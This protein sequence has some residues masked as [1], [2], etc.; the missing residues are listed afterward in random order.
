MMVSRFIS[1]AAACRD[2]T[3]L[4]IIQKLFTVNTRRYESYFIIR[5]TIYVTQCK[6]ASNYINTHA[7]PFNG[8]FSRTIRVILLKQ[9]TVSGSGISWEICKSAPRARQITTPAIHHSVFYRPCPSNYMKNSVI[10][11]CSFK[12]K[13]FPHLLRYCTF[14]NNALRNHNNVYHQ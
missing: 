11:H 10:F 5:V 4:H 7:Q 9:E 14:G 8:L 2:C 12:I 1:S 6:T 3:M 13:L